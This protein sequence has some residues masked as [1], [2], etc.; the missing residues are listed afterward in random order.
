M[1]LTFG[2][3]LRFFNRLSK[4]GKPGNILKSGAES[5]SAALPGSNSSS[6][7]T[8]VNAIPSSSVMTQIYPAGFVLRRHV[9][10]FHVPSF[11]LGLLV[12]LPSVIGLLVMCVSINYFLQAHIR[13][14]YD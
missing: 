13:I 2:L 12:L 5:Y 4:Q 11:V 14:K 1:K 7:S 6:S 8:L 9:Y 3:L 10:V